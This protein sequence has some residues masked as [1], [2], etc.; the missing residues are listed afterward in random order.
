M[1]L[2]S[3][4]KGGKLARM[5]NGT[6][7]II[8]DLG[9]VKGGKGLRHHECLL[10]FGV[11]SKLV[12]IFSALA[13]LAPRTE[14]SRPGERPSALTGALLHRSGDVDASATAHSAQ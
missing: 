4:F 3:Y 7:C 11:F 12:G 5:S 2:R 8:R 6:Y 9:L 10:R 13:N 1:G 14:S